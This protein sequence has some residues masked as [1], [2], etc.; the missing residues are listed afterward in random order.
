MSIFVILPNIS[1]IDFSILVLLL[2]VYG[3]ILDVLLPVFTFL[4]IRTPFTS[5]IC[6]LIKIQSPHQSSALID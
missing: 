1:H 6:P 3:I 2:L 4:P 5:L